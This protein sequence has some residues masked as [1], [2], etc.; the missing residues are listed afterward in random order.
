[1]GALAA[2]EK[3]MRL[4][5]EYRDQMEVAL[6]S[7]LQDGAYT[8]AMDL[9][10]PDTK[11]LSDRLSSLYR[12]LGQSHDALVELGT[13]A[14][15]LTALVRSTPVQEAARFLERLG[16]SPAGKVLDG[17]SN[18][19]NVYT[20]GKATYNVYNASTTNMSSGTLDLS[21]SH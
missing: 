9:A 2:A 11:R 3:E 20:T 10:D 6:Q 15:G 7:S 17:L 4:A 21:R 8:V 12:E 16:N 5:G 19:L 1:R 14:D 18:A 13:R